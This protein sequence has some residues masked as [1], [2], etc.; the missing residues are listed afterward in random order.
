MTH[1]NNPDSE[2]LERKI[3]ITNRIY[4]GLV[5]AAFVTLGA[6]LSAVFIF[7]VGA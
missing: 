7:I 3:K 2:R 5:P 6:F 1:W 4:R